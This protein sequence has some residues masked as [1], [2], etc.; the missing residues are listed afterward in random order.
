MMS[1]ACAALS[2]GSMGV[3]MTTFAV[4]GGGVVDGMGLDEPLKR[5]RKNAKTPAPPRM[6]GKRLRRL[7]RRY[8]AERGL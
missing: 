7:R 4:P 2:L 8:V 3:T 6:Y 1:F 5:Y